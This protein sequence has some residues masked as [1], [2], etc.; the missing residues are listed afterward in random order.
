MIVS[1]RSP[2]LPRPVVLLVDG[3]ADSLDVNSLA[4]S[5]AGFDVDTATDGVRTFARLAHRVPA[6]VALEL[7]LNGALSSY[8]VWYGVSA[9]S[10]RRA[11]RRVAAPRAHPPAEPSTA[12]ASADAI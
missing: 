5:R 12:D 8:Y 1:P 7:A 6:I 2:L 4:L 3:Y 9:K 10:P 11:T